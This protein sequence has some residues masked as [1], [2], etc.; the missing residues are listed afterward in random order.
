VQRSAR[1]YVAKE[2]GRLTYNALLGDNRPD[3]WPGPGLVHR[4]F[5]KDDNQW[6]F[7]LRWYDM[8]TAEYS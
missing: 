8:L 3:D 5:S 1:G 2:R 4:G 7:W 6:H